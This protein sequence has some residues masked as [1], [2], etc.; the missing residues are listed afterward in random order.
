MNEGER[1]MSPAPATLSVDVISC[2][3]ER[4]EADALVTP[5]FESDR[6]LRGPAARADWR[7]A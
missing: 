3:P 1:S 5:F 7:S 6:P 4:A 2:A